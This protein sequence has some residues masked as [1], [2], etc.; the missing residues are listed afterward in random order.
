VKNLLHHQLR[1][2]LPDCVKIW[3]F[4]ALWLGEAQAENDWREGRPQVEMHR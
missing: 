4:G 3:Y 1:R 2:A